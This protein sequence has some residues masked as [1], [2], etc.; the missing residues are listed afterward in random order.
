[1]TG[2]RTR[3]IAGGTALVAW[4]TAGPL[5]ALWAAGALYFL[6]HRE[7]PSGVTPFTWVEYARG[8]W[9]VA[10]ER[11]LLLLSVLVPVALAL[12]P[13]G[14]ILSWMAGPVPALHGDARFAFA[15]EVREAGLMSAA[16]I[17]VGKY[18]GRFLQ[19]P[20]QQFCLLAAP[21]RSGKGVSMVTPNLLNWP[22]SC[23]VLD[24][25]LENFLLTSKFRADHGQKVFLFNPFAED[26]LTH[27][28]NPLDGV[29]RDPHLRAGDLLALAT[30]LY[31]ALPGEKDAF[32]AES[33]R[34]LFLGMA[35]MVLETPELPS[36]I[37][38][39]MRQ[40]SGQGRGLKEY[41]GDRI[42][43]RDA[44]GQPYSHA[45]L[46]ALQRFMSA[47]ENTLANIISSFNAPLILFANPLVDAATS[48]SDFDITRIRDARMTIY[49]GI[50]PNRLAEATLLINVFFSQ[51][52]NLNTRTL[53]SADRHPYPCLLIL[54]EFPALGKINILAKANAFIA[55]YNLR[56][57]TIIQSIAQLEAVYGVQDA[58]TLMTN[59]AMQVLFTPREQ[60][61][62][63]AYSEMLGFTTVKSRS[64]GRSMNR[65]FGA[66]GSSSENLSDQRRAL[67]LPQEL[68]ALAED[69]QIIILENTRPIRC[70]KAR[71]YRDRNL[72]DRL[73]SVLVSR[74]TVKWPPSQAELEHLTFGER[75]L[76]A[77]VPVLDVA[78]HLAR[79]S[80]SL[81]PAVSAG[82]DLSTLEINPD[83][84]PE[85]T[86]QE[87]PSADEI[88]RL[89]E[90]FFSLANVQPD[91]ILF[92]QRSGG[93]AETFLEA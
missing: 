65:G 3:T 22:D 42:A 78:R 19:F 38:E 13:I 12:F 39:I 77:P 34:N 83:E 64:T 89:V 18:H 17:I 29:S 63:N 92:E 53:P 82:I 24:I 52:I 55:G 37:G 14:L 67:M 11:R 56:L 73:K 36:T 74:D 88:D 33:A 70:Q 86:D 46:D 20:G 91:E 23:V 72:M 16:G 54:D 27:R 69:E 76:A 25:K 30:S 44:I 35:L 51:L 6:M 40:S 28:W 2:T 79:L 43:A 15:S 59:H 41:L 5:V 21:T 85:I 61:D 58:R 10:G 68:K 31:P 48:A 26:G 45:C 84:L 75:R 32:W 60:R 49:I 71:Y 62:A 81:Q 57:L 4:L 87:N 93:P 9:S 66:G 80:R 47:T 90:T 8:Y 7:L 50:Q 1:M